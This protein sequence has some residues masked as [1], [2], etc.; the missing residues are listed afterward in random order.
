MGLVKLSVDMRADD[1]KPLSGLVEELLGQGSI[2]RLLTKHY[3]EYSD[4]GDCNNLARDALAS[5]VSS[6]QP[7]QEYQ[8]RAKST[9]VSETGSF[10]HQFFCGGFFILSAYMD[11]PKPRNPV[12]KTRPAP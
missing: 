7:K 5:R 2:T 12:T 3:K 6:G 8:C 10:K 9:A 11:R 4:F 1:T